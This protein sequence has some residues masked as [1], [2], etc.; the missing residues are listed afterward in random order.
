[1]FSIY[2]RESYSMYLCVIASY[3][4]ICTCWPIRQDPMLHKTSEAAAFRIFLSRPNPRKRKVDHK[5]LL[6]I[7]RRLL[8]CPWTYFHFNATSHALKCVFSIKTGSRET[9]SLTN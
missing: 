2:A 4:D 9:A 7:M 1:M 5:G 6:S 3:L 8:E